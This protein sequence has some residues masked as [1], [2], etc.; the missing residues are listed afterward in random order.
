MRPHSPTSVTA[1][2]SLLALQGHP[3]YS[4]SSSS[5]TGRMPSSS[6]RAGDGPSLPPAS[7]SS[8]SS[9]PYAT[10]HDSRIRSVYRGG[11]SG[12]NVA[13]PRAHFKD[14]LSS[15]PSRSRYP[16]AQPEQAGRGDPDG[17]GTS[18]W[19]RPFPS[20]STH[21]SPS[22]S[23]PGSAVSSHRP[24]P[25]QRS[26]TYAYSPPALDHSQRRGSESQNGFKS[27]SEHQDDELEVAEAS[28]EA[29]FLERH[30]ERHLADHDPGRRRSSVAALQSPSGSSVITL[31]KP[32]ISEETTSYLFH[33]FWCG[34]SLHWPL[35]YRK[36]FSSE[37]AARERI[38]EEHPLLF[39][40]ICSIA[41]LIHSETDPFRL[42]DG[43]SHRRLSTIFYAR[44]RY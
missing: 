42:P 22:Y 8:K 29:I 36:G 31:R 17:H 37:T 13:A 34:I 1:S 2:A 5:H 26:S 7:S 43:L 6:H 23:V 20:P 28:L 38:E 18:R 10:S 40:A 39:N 44:A 11:T 16:I 24:A 4:G 25:L 3:A 33:V 14:E 12:W 9:W 41:A 35:F 30:E 32:V 21:H 15:S 19:S 27:M